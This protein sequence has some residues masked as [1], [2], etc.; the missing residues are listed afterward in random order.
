[1][2]N[3]KDIPGET[4]GQQIGEFLVEFFNLLGRHACADSG[5]GSDAT[6]PRLR[7]V[8]S[9]DIVRKCLDP[10]AA[11]F[12]EIAEPPGMHPR[13]PSQLPV[14]VMTL[15]EF[16]GCANHVTRKREPIEVRNDQN[17]IASENPRDLR[18]Y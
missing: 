15:D 4:R 14:G 1:M 17:A 10:T 5:A 9:I 7:R 8:W 12:A 2:R 16:F 18:S 13:A 6:A 3:L 11:G